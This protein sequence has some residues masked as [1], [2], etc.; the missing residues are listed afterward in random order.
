MVYIYKCLISWYLWFCCS[1]SG[2]EFTSESGLFDLL[3]IGLY[4]GWLADPQDTP[5]WE[6]VSG[7]SYN[8]LVEKVINDRQSTDTHKLQEGTDLYDCHSLP[9]SVLSIL[10]EDTKWTY[11]QS[12]TWC[13]LRL[14]CS[15]CHVSYNIQPLRLTLKSLIETIMSKSHSSKVNS[16][17]ST[18][19]LTCAR[20]M[21]REPHS[22]GLHTCAQ[23]SI[24][25]FPDVLY[26]AHRKCPTMVEVR[27]QWQE[28]RR[29]RETGE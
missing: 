21:L 23:K 16:Y 11:V 18:S 17:S 4:H 20:Y 12:Q 27:Q 28:E 22:L 13:V 6:A 5:T 8:Q 1:V 25:S 9:W 19:V 29:A 26:V 14:F 7:C 15:C 3:D 24:V 10:W 2:F